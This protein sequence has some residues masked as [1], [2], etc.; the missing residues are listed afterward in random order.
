MTGEISRSS[1]VSSEQGSDLYTPPP[2]NPRLD[3]PY[4]RWVKSIGVPVHE[5]YYVE[6]LRTMEVG[7][8]AERGCDA[9]V[10][11]LRGQEGLTEARVLEIAP[12]A[13]VPPWK[14]ALDE[15]VYV[16]E[17]NGL[18]TVWARDGGPRKTVEWQKHSLFLIPHCH[19]YELTNMRGDRPARLLQ[20][21]YLPLAMS[22]LADPRFYFNNPYED[23]DLLLEKG[24]EFYS[25][26]KVSAGSG[27]GS[28]RR[29]WYGNFF[30]DLRVWDKIDP[31]E[32]RGAGGHGTGFRFPA[33]E[34]QMHMSVFP[35][36]TYKKAHRHRAGAVI[37]IPTGEGYSLMWPEGGEK[38]I[39]P[40]HEASVFVPPNRWFHQH[41]NVG[42]T[43]ARY[44]ALHAPLSF[45]IGR[46][47]EQI[48][49]PV[50]D[51]IEY[52]DEEPWI[53]AKFEEE[54]AKRSLTSLMPEE[55]YRAKSFR[56]SYG[57]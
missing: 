50:R 38:V 18:L 24:D 46:G 14:F 9:A 11:L 51:Q 22:T 48:E 10:L 41:F 37:V 34:H 52:P 53:R 15:A 31:K 12:G 54:L 44:L 19:T 42:S 5:G 57:D 25:A 13:V 43:P 28:R 8:W 32:G 39:A 27:T 21:S 7:R 29:T 26:A 33:S 3:S 40:W 35:T 16:V 49:D 2:W 55:A 17:G 4:K 23:P 47:T 20:H 1:G 56:W 45:N 30:P 6:D 36:R